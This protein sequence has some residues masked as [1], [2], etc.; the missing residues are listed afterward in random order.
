[1]ELILDILIHANLHFRPII[2]MSVK[3]IS[4]RH[5]ANNELFTFDLTLQ[6]VD[7]RCSFSAIK[8]RTYSSQLLR[9]RFNIFVYQRLFV[10]FD[11]QFFSVAYFKIPFLRGAKCKGR[12]HSNT[13]HGCHGYRDLRLSEAFYWGCW[14]LINVQRTSRC[15][16]HVDMVIKANVSSP[17]C[18]L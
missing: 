4:R 18:Y 11:R 1:M 10:Y 2:T 8:Y 5:V 14:T 17:T 13:Q 16:K 15:C 7:G 12:C 3:S 6:L 9:R